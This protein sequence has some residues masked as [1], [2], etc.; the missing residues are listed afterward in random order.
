MRAQKSKKGHLF[1]FFRPDFNRRLRNC[2]E[3]A[4]L[5]AK[6]A[7]FTAGEELHLAPKIYLSLALY[8]GERILSTD[9]NSNSCF[10]YT[11]ISEYFNFTESGRKKNAFAFI[12]S[13][14]AVFVAKDSVAVKGNKRNK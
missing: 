3:S 8:T 13:Q 1:F 10:K 6:F 4:L 2:T 14:H 5:K 7:G 12:K 11:D 9:F